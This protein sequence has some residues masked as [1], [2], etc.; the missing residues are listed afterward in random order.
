MV[1]AVELGEVCG[2]PSPFLVL[3]L[4]PDEHLVRPPAQ[5]GSRVLYR[6]GPY[7][8]DPDATSLAPRHRQFG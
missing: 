5:V 1:E 4:E 2:M 6:V 3:E 8:D 7:A